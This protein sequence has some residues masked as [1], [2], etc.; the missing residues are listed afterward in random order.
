[1]A[2]TRKIAIDL[3]TTNTLMYVPKKGIVLNEPSVVAIS[4]DNNAVLAIGRQAQQMIGRTP[5]TITAH[6]P[7]KDGVIADFRIA[8]AMLRYLIK[9]TGASVKFFRPEVLVSV[10]ANITSTERRAVVDATLS[11]GAK[12]VYLIKEPVAAAIGA[13]IPI[14]E[15]SGHMIVDIGGG[16]TEAAVISL[17]GVVS[18]H[19]SRVGGNVFDAAIIEHIRKRYGLVI[20]EPTAEF[21]KKEIG[22]AIP[23]EEPESLSVRGR[24]VATGLPKETVI[25]SHE[26]TEALREPLSEVMLTIKHVLQDTPPELSADIIDKGIVLTG[27]GAALKNI[28]QLIS[29]GTAVPVY[30]ADDPLVCVVKGAGA[31]LDNLETYK[32]SILLTK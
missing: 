28:D 3:G 16:T 22:S 24:D 6:R 10:P 9:Q 11:A 21:I 32:R 1:M 30:I 17:G 19:S 18:A 23:E 27:G 20:G 29:H 12:S 15:S 26:V 4:S 8:E 2:L 5:E 7:L 14:G 13:N 25:S 31:A